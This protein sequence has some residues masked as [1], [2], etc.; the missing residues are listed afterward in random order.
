[1]CPKVN[2][3]WCQDV[4]HQKPILMNTTQGS[5]RLTLGDVQKIFDQCLL[6]LCTGSILAEVEFSKRKNLSRSKIKQQNQRIQKFRESYKRKSLLTESRCRLCQKWYQIAYKNHQLIQQFG[7]NRVYTCR[8]CLLSRSNSYNDQS[9]LIPD[10]PT[11]HLPGT[12]G[13]IE[14]M[15][16]RYRKNQELFHPDDALYSLYEDFSL[17]NNYQNNCRVIPKA[18]REDEKFE[19][20]ESSVG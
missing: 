14:V 18:G 10:R 4:W 3:S 16:Q 11:H 2:F 1:M 8:V 6:F 20:D 19:E 7:L 5:S 13:K 17:L 15:I 9:R 12:P